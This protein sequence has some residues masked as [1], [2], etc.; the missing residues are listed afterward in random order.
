MSWTGIAYRSSRPVDSATPGAHGPYH[1]S[2][3]TVLR[4]ET[5]ELLRGVE[6]WRE[7]WRGLLLARQRRGRR[8]VF[9]PPRP[10]EWKR[11]RQRV[12]RQRRG[13]LLARQR[14]GLR[15]VVVAARPIMEIVVIP[16]APVALIEVG[17]IVLSAD[18]VTGRAPF[19]FRV[20]LILLTG[21]RRGGGRLRQPCCPQGRL[22]SAQLKLWPRLWCWLWM[23]RQPNALW[24]L[25]S[26]SNSRPTPASAF[27]CASLFA[28]FASDGS[29]RLMFPRSP[30]RV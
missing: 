1:L 14:R 4:T 12:P 24:Q 7:L 19:S 2:R 28:F 25:C 23:K 16:I 20:F 3:K 27:V 5:G 13:L 8:K 29:R 18:V 21:K 10:I 15:K 17:P 26:L 11:R 22:F 9:I 6:L 30:G